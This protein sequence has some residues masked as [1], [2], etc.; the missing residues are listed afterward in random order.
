MGQVG[1]VGGAGWR[2]DR[3]ASLGIVARSTI[4]LRRAGR[5]AVWH[6]FFT[7]LSLFLFA[8]IAGSNLLHRVLTFCRVQPEPLLRLSDTGIIHLRGKGA[9]V[10]V[11]GDR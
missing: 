3:L 5:F 4:G 2:S 6:N 11:L 1:G 10:G 9:G 8:L 7:I